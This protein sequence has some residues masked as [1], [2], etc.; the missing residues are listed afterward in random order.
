MLIIII[1][2]G[3]IIMHSSSV[4][5]LLN[6]IWIKVKSILAPFLSYKIFLFQDRRLKAPWWRWEWDCP[7]WGRWRPW[8]TST[9]CWAS[10]W[11]RS[12]AAANLPSWGASRQRARVTVLTVTVPI[13]VSELNQKGPWMCTTT[14]SFSS[15]VF[16]FK[17]QWQMAIRNLRSTDRDT[18]QELGRWH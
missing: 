16:A 15:P 6:Q 10:W 5:H 7:N 1:I 13:V 2:D 11:S 3:V 4:G 9:W 17:T 14:R 8:V 18:D 12:T